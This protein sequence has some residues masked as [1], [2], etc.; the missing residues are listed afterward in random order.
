MKKQLLLLMMAAFGMQAG[1]QTVSDTHMTSGKNKGEIPAAKIVSLKNHTNTSNAKGPGTPNTAVAIFSEDFAAGLPATW[2]AVDNIGNGEIWTYTT[3]GASGGD[4]LSSVGTSAANGYML[5]DSDLGG[6][7]TGAEDA[8]LK[9][10]AINCSSNASVFLS[11]NE[12]FLQYAISIGLVSVST[13]GTTWTDVYHAETGLGQNQTLGNPHAVQIDISSIAANQATVY[14]RFK[15][16][17]DYDWYWMIDD[18]T[19]YEPSGVDVSINGIDDISS[20]TL[21]GAASITVAV[22][23]KLTTVSNIPVSYSING[24]TPVTETIAG[25]MNPLDTVIYTFTATANLGTLGT[26]TIEAYTGLSGDADNSND[27]ASIVVR[28]G[29]TQVSTGS[30]FNLGFETTDVELG[31]VTIEDV[32]ADGVGFD[33]SNT[34]T[35]SGGLCARKPYSASLAAT[36]EDY[37]YTGCIDLVGGTNYVLEYWFKTFTA[38]SV[39]YNLES[40]IGTAAGNA[41]MTQ[42]IS[43][44]ANPTDS[45][46]HQ[47]LTTFSVPTTGTYFVGLRVYGAGPQESLRIDDIR[48]SI[49]SSVGEVANSGGVSVYPN[50]SAGILNLS[51]KKFENANVRVFN[52]LGEEVYSARLNDIN[53]VLNLENFNSGLYVVKVEGNGFTYN[54]K[55]TI[56]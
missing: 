9:T 44:D 50:P 16:T 27:T 11:F 42:I 18:V 52:V 19:L 7:T 53:T 35:H 22:V 36:T 37:L 8:D 48:L 46:Y 25:P 41:S 49:A 1:A 12:Y 13:D 55:V 20:C 30:P 24:G 28:S 43:T 54:E 4:T 15:W 51:V 39:Q 31:F 33:L 10:P 21:N 45:S 3:V 47:S 6:T 5:F 2:S 38:A 29:P 34:Y 17:G 56:Q 23:N 14:V 26:Y 32:D 40:R